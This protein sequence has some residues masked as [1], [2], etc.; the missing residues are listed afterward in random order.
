MIFS[1]W[2]FCGKSSTRG[3]FCL[4]C[5][6]HGLLTLDLCVAEM[7]VKEDIHSVIHFSNIESSWLLWCHTN[8]LLSRKMW[9]Y[10][11][12]IVLNVFGK[13]RMLNCEAPAVYQ[14]V[15]LAFHVISLSLLI[16]P[17][18]CCSCFYLG[19]GYWTSEELPVGSS[20]NRRQ[21]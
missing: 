13:E 6:H 15:C 14:A 5:E 9:A 16:R 4:L 1:S 17:G 10:L 3:H 20:A 8:I 2:G 7:G 11:S 18:S 12:V 19:D 21:N